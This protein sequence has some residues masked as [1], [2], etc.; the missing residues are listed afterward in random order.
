MSGMTGSPYPGDVV[1]SAVIII[2]IADP[3][4]A[5]SPFPLPLVLSGPGMPGAVNDRDGG[6]SVS[7]LPARPSID[8]QPC[9]FAL[10]DRVLTA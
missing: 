9:A 5:T 4:S 6:F 8:A 3:A 2:I 10:S 7:A 1:E